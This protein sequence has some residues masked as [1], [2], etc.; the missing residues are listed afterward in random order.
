MQDGD[1]AEPGGGGHHGGA[2]RPRVPARAAQV[3]RQ[4]RLT[5]HTPLPTKP[6]LIQ[7]NPAAVFTQVE[8]PGWNAEGTLNGVRTKENVII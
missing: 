6:D 4:P 5:S 3:L 7:P 2:G 8:K 1:R